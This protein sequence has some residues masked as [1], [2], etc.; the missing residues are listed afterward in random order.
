MIGVLDETGILKYG[1][2]F[3]QYS[4]HIDKP[5]VAKRICRGT[6][7]VTKFPALAPGDIRKFEAID[8]EELHHM[9]DC[10]VFPQHGHRPHPDEMAGSD[11]D[12]DEYFVTWMP[13][14][15]F[16]GDN[17]EP[18][19]FTPPQKK[20]H[21]GA[22]EV[23]DMIEYIAN[24]IKN[25]KVGL[26]ANAHLAQADR[27]TMGIFSKV[28][29]DIAEI[30]S[31][32]VDFA[33]T[34]YSPDLGEKQRPYRYP[35]FMG[36]RDKSTYRSKKILG[37]LF[38]Q[39]RHIDRLA[40]QQKESTLPNV[41]YDAAL[42]Y[43]G[44]E[45]FKV[46]AQ[47]ALKRYNR[48]LEAILTQYG[49]TSESEALSGNIG[50]LSKRV[51]ERNEIYDAK[52][53]I[54]VK[55]KHLW[56]KTRHSFFEEFGGRDILLTFSEECLAKASAWYITTYKQKDKKYI[57]FPWV[58]H[59]I[60]CEIRQRNSNAVD[61]EIVTVPTVIRRLSIEMV[62][63][64]LKASNESLYQTVLRHQTP[65]AEDLPILFHY[66]EEN[67]WLRSTAGALLE[68]REAQGLEKDIGK[69]ELLV[70][71][72]GYAINKRYIVEA[73]FQRG[74]GSNDGA[75]FDEIAVE[76]LVE[77]LSYCACR[78]FHQENLRYVPGACQK[79]QLSKTHVNRVSTAAE[80]AY[81]QLALCGTMRSIFQKKHD[82]PNEEAIQVSVT[83]G[84]DLFVSFAKWE[85]KINADFANVELT[86]RQL[87]HGKRPRGMVSIFGPVSQ[88]NEVQ[89]LIQEWESDS[90]VF[91]E[92]LMEDLFDPF[93]DIFDAQHHDDDDHDVD[94]DLEAV[95]SF[96]E[97]INQKH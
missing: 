91:Q 52:N 9:V 42:E 30:F 78:M 17:E 90:S 31:K 49:I 57:S 69:I 11:L 41:P 56:K 70:L 23:P 73:G 5:Q 34:G 40:I 60:L 3:V 2:V 93:D 36:K 13:E 53:I 81:H 62:E 46:D 77:F 47:K 71:L 1:Q 58:V 33:K 24:Y 65:S 19:D 48:Q 51:S 44:R 64:R 35:D 27:Q 22:I 67:P 74:E 28:C 37:H 88:V 25:D 66:L 8:V 75:M 87:G 80:K 12:G 89:D 7:V 97:A 43:P 16:E 6:V 94:L 72:I 26:I 15:M 84:N 38:R 76:L 4:K 45:F 92:D 85:Q 61:T 54:T 96:I 20:I 63:C 83:V 14:L 18:M 32:A 82:N 68:W 86:M 21:E 39:C 55:V 10:V 50:R 79:P 59:D 29:I 95:L